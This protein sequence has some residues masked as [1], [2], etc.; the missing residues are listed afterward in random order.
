MAEAAVKA[1]T[2]G[3]QAKSD[4]PAALFSE[5]FH[6][7]LVHDAARAEANAPG[8]APLPPSAAARSR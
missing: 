3:K 1:P 7:S 8:A 6:E 2:L 4:L 5:S